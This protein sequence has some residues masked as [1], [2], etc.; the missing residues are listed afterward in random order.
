MPELEKPVITAMALIV[1]VDDTVKAVE[2]TVDDV[3]GSL[4]FV[5]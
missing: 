5:V 4:P 1:V 3:V 2:Y